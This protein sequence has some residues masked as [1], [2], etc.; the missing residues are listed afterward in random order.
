MPN[1][2][3]TEPLKSVLVPPTMANYESRC[4]D[5]GQTAIKP[6][7]LVY[8]SGSAAANAVTLA[9]AFY[10]DAV[11]TESTLEIVEIP[12]S[13]PA[14]PKMYEKDTAF[15][16]IGNPGAGFKTHKIDK[17]DIVWLQGSSLTLVED[18]TIIVCADNGLAQL[19]GGTT[20]IDKYNVHAF[21]AK[22][23]GSSLDDFM[24]EYIG[25]IAVDSA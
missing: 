10:G 20:T 12:A 11:K 13:N 21:K 22:Q 25:R 3:R 15:P 17:G 6:G 5:T 24:A 18:E 9:T 16:A 4:A 19:P 23:S 8:K 1:E 14:F 2:N 7:L